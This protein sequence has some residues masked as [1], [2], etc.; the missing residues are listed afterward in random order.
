MTFLTHILRDTHLSLLAAFHSLYTRDSEAAIT[1]MQD[2]IMFALSPLISEISHL[3]TECDAHFAFHKPVNRTAHLE[4]TPM[5]EQYKQA[6]ADVLRAHIRSYL[7]TATSTEEARAA[8]YTL[9]RSL[10]ATEA[11]P[12]KRARMHSITMQYVRGYF[13]GLEDGQALAQRKEHA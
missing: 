12:L 13:N 9:C 8:A 3:R 11:D 7:E 6:F 4:E 5:S 2:A 10:S 1:H